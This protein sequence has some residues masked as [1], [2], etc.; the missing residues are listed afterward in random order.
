MSDPE[1]DKPECACPAPVSI[2]GAYAKLAKRLAGWNEEAAVCAS[3]RA[4][5][6]FD[7][8][9]PVEPYEIKPEEEGDA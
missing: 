6:E 2:D 4:I 3:E 7:P 1:D 9:G 8:E 5:I